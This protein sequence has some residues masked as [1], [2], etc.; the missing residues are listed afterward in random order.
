[1]TDQDD[2]SERLKGLILDE[3]QV[4]CLSCNFKALHK[5]PMDGLAKVMTMYLLMVDL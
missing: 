1:M 4:R 5:R 2:W 3:N